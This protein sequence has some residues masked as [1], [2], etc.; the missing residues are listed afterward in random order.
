[1]STA[2]ADDK[3]EQ[4]Q[5]RLLSAGGTTCIASQ[6]GR[7]WQPHYR[8]QAGHLRDSDVLAGAL[9]GLAARG[10]PCEQ[11]AAKAVAAHAGGS[12]CHWQ[13]G[14]VELSAEVRQTIGHHVFGPGRFRD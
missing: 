14:A 7:A 13:L 1:M 10:V 3:G 5:R 12:S 11:A 8:C 9:A 4:T 2:N 6:D